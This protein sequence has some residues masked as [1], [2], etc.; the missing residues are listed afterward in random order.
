MA[1]MLQLDASLVGRE[2]PERTWS[3]TWRDA[4]L[5][6]LGIGA[7]P[8]PG[9]LTE[10]GADEGDLDFLF[11]RRGPKVFPTLAVIPGMKAIEGV[12]EIIELD[13]ARMLH[14][15]QAITLHRPFP[16][17][18]TVRILGRIAEVWD[19][20]GAAVVGVE[21][22]LVDDD[23][24]LAT[25]TASLFAKGYGG[26]GGER[27]PDTA[28]RNQPPH[29]APDHVVEDTV[30]VEQAA[31]YRLSGDRV[32]LHI[33]PEFARRA[34][35]PGPFLHGLCTYGFVGRAVLKT[36]CGNDP[37]RL[38]SFTGRFADLVWLG[39]TIVTK[40]WVEDDGSA[41]VSAETQR[42][43]VVLAQSAAQVVPA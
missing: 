23:G 41:I 10:A 29:R 12:R 2:L 43:N 15:E 4:V 31:I 39:D 42:G 30:N 34:G 18:G 36:L 22:D 7:R 38:R 17:E 35:Y 11:E 32:P 8:G 14:G 28:G 40:M 33:D 5:Y 21:A 13:L 19:K 24:L 16:P 37:T 26:F 20:G 6:G 3:W 25:T 27:G 1:E 9:A